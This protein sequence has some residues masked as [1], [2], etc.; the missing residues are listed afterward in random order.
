[1]SPEEFLKEYETSTAKHGLDYT[2]HMI[3]DEAVYWF[4]DGTQHVGK[5]AVVA[6]IRHNFEAIKNEKY[7]INDV[8]WL[9]KTDEVAVGIFHYAWSGLVNDLPASGEGRGSIVIKRYGGSWRITHEH[10]SK[11]SH[12]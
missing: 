5:E 6:A 2:L 9:I 12:N 8:K 3:D 11:G 7:A 4:S 1:M 10:L